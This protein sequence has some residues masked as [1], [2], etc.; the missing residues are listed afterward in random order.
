METMV[1][2]LSDVLRRVRGEYG[3]M[4]GLNLTLPQAQRLWGLD[5]C[6]CEAVLRNLVDAHF[7]RRT[8]KGTFVRFDSDSPAAEFNP[9][10]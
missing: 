6:A 3:E 7:L 4:P 5:T 8:P 10:R 1:L 9:W 2:D